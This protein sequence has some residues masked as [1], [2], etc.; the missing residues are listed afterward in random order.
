MRGTFTAKAD[1]PLLTFLFEHLPEVKR[2]KVRQ[3]LKFKG[4]Q[5]NGRVVVRADHTLRAGDTVLLEPK[6]KAL[7]GPGLP[8]GMRIIHDDAAV[9][10]IEKP[11]GLL[12]IATEK[13]Q[14]AT[15]YAKLTDYVRR[16]PRG[17]ENRVWIV[18]RLDR[19][20][21]GLMVFARTEEAKRSLQGRWDLAQKKYLAVV[22]G[23]PP[24]PR[25]TLRS[26]LDES[27]AFRVRSTRESEDTREAITH[28]RL[29]R[30][31]GHRALVELTLE[32]G[33]RHQI[34]VQ[35]AEIGCPIV[36]DPKYHPG[37][38]TNKRMALHASGLK[39]P[40]PDTGE[41]LSFKSAL[42]GELGRLMEPGD[43]T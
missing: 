2:T 6:A 29:V 26:H 42:P 15:A 19:E 41:L 4:V 34:R 22:D 24:E 23:I 27:D 17:R 13:E 12:S 14:E 1:G 5:V 37:G 40:H 3:W 10:V 33:R 30:K 39:F 8:S 36:G 43:A 35:L 31:A 38:V 32:T 18:H 11:A 28:Y 25:G 20:T 21:S 7:P 16:T 9:I